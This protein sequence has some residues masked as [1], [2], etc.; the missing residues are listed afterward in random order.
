MNWFWIEFVQLNWL[1]LCD[2]LTSVCPVRCVPDGAG[3]RGQESSSTDAQGSS[4][5][6]SALILLCTDTLRFSFFAKAS[7][8]FNSFIDGVLLVLFKLSSVSVLCW[9]LVFYTWSDRR[10][11]AAVICPRLSLYALLYCVYQRLCA[12][13]FRFIFIISCRIE[14]KD[15]SAS[16]LC[17]FLLF[18]SQKTH[19]IFQEYIETYKKVFFCGSQSRNPLK[20]ENQRF[21]TFSLSFL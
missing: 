21:L 10:E 9:F 12:S 16:S 2:S 15:S 1:N 18:F 11:A 17:L 6:D 20:D 8:F 5:E 3:V 19:T 13:S 14:T 7:V 4:S